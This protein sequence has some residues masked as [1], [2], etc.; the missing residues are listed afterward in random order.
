MNYNGVLPIVNIQ[1]PQKQM[2]NTSPDT[3]GYNIEHNIILYPLC[4]R[5]HSP[6]NDFY[7][8]TYNILR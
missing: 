7:L 8:A 5:R 6:H 2:E 3:S 1:V 4:G